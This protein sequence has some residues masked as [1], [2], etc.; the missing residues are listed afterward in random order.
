MNVEVAVDT[1]RDRST[2]CSIINIVEPLPH[3]Y[4][5]AQDPTSS[6]R[7]SMC[8]PRLALALKTDEMGVTQTLHPIGQI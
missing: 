7:G 2:A 3:D 6:D 4:I 5:N 8:C 1:D